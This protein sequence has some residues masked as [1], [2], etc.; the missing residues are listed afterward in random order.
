MDAIVVIAE[1]EGGHALLRQTREVGVVVV[2]VIDA[3]REDRRRERRRRRRRVLVMWTARCV[4]TCHVNVGGVAR[5]D[6]LA[7]RQKPVVI[8]AGGVKKKRKEKNYL[9]AGC[10]DSRGKA[11]GRLDT[12]VHAKATATGGSPSSSALKILVAEMVVV[13][14]DGVMRVMVAV[15]DTAGKCVSDGVCMTGAYLPCCKLGVLGLRVVVN[16]I[17]GDDS[18]DRC[19]RCRHHWG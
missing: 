3:R 15:D 17:D 5:R 10:C 13:V 4:F 12:V 19:R 8:N 14:I 7:R 16:A 1:A 9:L 2:V 6:R 11:G 18:C